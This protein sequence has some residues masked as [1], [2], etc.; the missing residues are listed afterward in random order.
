MAP[1]GSP[2]QPE[3]RRSG[4]RFKPGLRGW[5]AGGSPA[6]DSDSEPEAVSGGA[7]HQATALASSPPHPGR[8]RPGARP[9][10]PESAPGPGQASRCAGLSVAAAY[11][12]EILSCS[13]TRDTVAPSGGLPLAAEPE[14]R[15]RQ[16]VTY[17]E[18]GGQHPV[19]LGVLLFLPL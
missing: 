19:R 9:A 14:C 4:A 3:W 8:S 2:R 15:L 12:P 11:V 18:L 10:A 6:R 13:A 5:P 1:P 17:H 7:A 16:E